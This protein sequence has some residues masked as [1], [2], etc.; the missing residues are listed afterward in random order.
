M[1]ESTFAYANIIASFLYQEVHAKEP[2]KAQENKYDLPHI[3]IFQY[4]AIKIYANLNE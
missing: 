2:S 3:G 4:S 1:S